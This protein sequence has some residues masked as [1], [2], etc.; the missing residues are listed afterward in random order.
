MKIKI[1][2]NFHFNYNFLKCTARREGLNLKPSFKLR[3]FRARNLWWITNASDY[4]MVW[5][6]NLLHTV[7]SFNMPYLKGSQ[8]KMSCGHWNLSPMIN[9]EYRTIE[10]QIEVIYFSC[11]LWKDLSLTGSVQVN[12]FILDKNRLFS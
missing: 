9:H 1:S 3:W 5:N 10:V 6:V 7:Y 4:R 8:F 12:N 2:V 11:W